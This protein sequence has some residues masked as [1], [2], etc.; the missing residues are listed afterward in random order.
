MISWRGDLIREDS[1]VLGSQVSQR[2][3]QM[4]GRFHHFIGH[5][6]P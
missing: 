6:G 3:L 2:T 4:V 1:M 5:K